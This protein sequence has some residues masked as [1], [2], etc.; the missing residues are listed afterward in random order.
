MKDR[1]L[2]V[3]TTDIHR[4]S[5]GG[6][7][8]MAFYKAFFNA[9]SDRLDIIQFKEFQKN[10]DVNSFGVPRQSL[11]KKV[12][13][14]MK[15][16]IHRFN[17]WLLD[18]L[19]RD[20]NKY[21]S[22]IINSG[23]VGDI[24]DDIK[25]HVENVIIIHHN[26]EVDFQMDNNGPTTLGGIFPYFVK[27]NEKKSYLKADLNLFLT[28][29]DRQR[30]VQ[31]YGKIDSSKTFVIGVFDTEDFLPPCNGKTQSNILCITGG[32]NNV[33]S[34]KGI[35]DFQKY[36]GVINEIFE[37]RYKIIIAGR[38]P[39]NYINRL[40][41]LNEKLHLVPNPIDMNNVIS[42]AGIF[43]CPINVGS[44]LKLRIMDGLR[45]GKPI[46]THEVSAYGYEPFYNEE[47]FQ[48]YNDENS[49]ENGLL[50]ILNYIESTPN[51]F[52]IIRG[53]Y[54][55]YFSYTCGSTRLLNIVDHLVR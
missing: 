41:S 11:A 39:G 54:S 14:L 52:D 17:P 44:G 26:C 28:E 32:L 1:I 8:H 20:S 24:I 25:K 43:L 49:F 21:G 10:G 55:K 22:I 5:G 46:L 31:L 50:A 38:N 16:V 23:I 3:A 45:L 29:H 53:A 51:H 6:Y 2:F 34:I 48:V 15:G 4:K 7:A 18:F 37:K 13:C 9:Y 36:L 35:K 42:N 40:C 27:R 33:Q 19:K 47:W 12:G 30:F